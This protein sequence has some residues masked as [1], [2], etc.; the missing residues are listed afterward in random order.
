MR[1]DS[2]AGRAKALS[3]PVLIAAIVLALAA[4]SAGATVITAFPVDF[5]ATE[6]TQFNDFVATFSDDNPSAGPADF[7]A[8]VDWG[9]GSPTSSG[10]IFFNS[11]AFVVVAQH[12]YA[13]EGSFT[14]TVTIADVSPG[15]GTATVS[16]SATVQEA[17]VLSGTPKTF[18]VPSGASFTVVVATFTDTYTAAVPS[19]F[20]ATINWGDATVSSGTV[21]GGGGTFQVSGTHTYAGTGTFAVTVTLQDDTPGTATA[22]VQST[23]KVAAGLA[24][25]GTDFSTPE[26]A[27][28]N[29]QVA[30]F[31]DANTALTP[32]SFTATINWGDSTTTAGTI[33]GSSGAFAVSGTHS[34]ADEG[35]FTVSTTVTETGPGG[36]TAAGSGTATVTETDVLSGSPMVFS[37]QASTPFSGPVATFTD[38]DTVTAASDLI[39]TIN[40]GDGNTTAG[41]VSGGSGSFTVSGTHT[42]AAAGSLPVIVTLTDDPPGTASATTTS[43]AN[44]AAAPVVVVPTLDPRG[45]VLLGLGFVAVAL[46]RLRAKRSRERA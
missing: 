44:V 13:D 27:A 20:T 22:T 30:T 24:V 34:Y 9:D 35:A 31:S 1:H 15:T 36:L 5:V 17:D 29:G 26:H 43:T 45:L 7:T 19:D 32:A 25:A 11:G 2:F 10:S 3:G 21:A 38:T 16:D 42:Y 40:W 4:G 8:T 14:A 28:F 33:T 46:H 41:T 6:G 12:T 39:A 23:A 37:A 18:S